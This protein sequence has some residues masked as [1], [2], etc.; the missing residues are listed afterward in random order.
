MHNVYDFDTHFQIDVITRKFTQEH[1]TKSTIMQYDHN[2]ERF[3]FEIPRMIEGHDVMDCTNVEIHYINVGG[4]T[5]ESVKGVYEVEDLQISPEDE[6]IAVFSW[7]ISSNATSL[8][9]SLNFLIRFSCSE[10]GTLTYAWSTDVYKKYSITSGMNNGNDVAYQYADVLEQWRKELN[11]IAQGVDGFSPVV[12]LDDIDTG[13]VITVTNEDGEISTLIRH[14][15]DGEKGETGE[16][17]DTGIQGEK[18]DT[19]MYVGEDEPQGDDVLF[20]VNPNG[21]ALTL[22]DEERALIVEEVLPKVPVVNGKDGADGK[23]PEKGVDYFTD[24]DINEIVDA[25]YRKVANGNEVAY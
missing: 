1:S 18:G 24:A 19:G 11:E 4:K 7:L 8:V 15:K 14:G 13:V 23:T 9:G 17:G 6:N 25:V 12:K 22:S 16:K 10:N 5:N 21:D 3:T 20:W 2:S